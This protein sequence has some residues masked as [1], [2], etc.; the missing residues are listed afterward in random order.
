MRVSINN[1]TTDIVAGVQMMQ[2]RIE[3]L[4]HDEEEKKDELMQRQVT[5][6]PQ[7]Y[8][9]RVKNTFLWVRQRNLK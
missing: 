7:P 8:V 6:I 9:S 3:A 4:E 1:Q 5:V 2:E